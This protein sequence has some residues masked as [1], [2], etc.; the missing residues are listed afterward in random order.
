MIS[1]FS[2]QEKDSD[3][4][5]SIIIKDFE[6]FGLI[7][8]NSHEVAGLYFYYILDHLVE[9][10]YSVAVDF[11]VK[12]FHL[13]TNNESS[14]ALSLLKLYTRM[15][16]DEVFLSKEHR[17][18]IWNSL[19]G[20]PK[21]QDNYN[22][23]KYNFPEL[24]DTLLKAASDYVLR[25][26][27]ETGGPALISSFRLSLIPFKQ[28]I[29]SV[30][31]AAAKLYRNQ[32]FPRLTEENVYSILRNPSVTAVYGINTAV[33]AN[34]PYSFDSNANKVIEEVSCQLD[35]VDEYGHYFTQKRESYLET[36]AKRGAVAIAS[37]VNVDPDGSSDQE[38]LSLINQCYA[39]YTALQFLGMNSM[40][41]EKSTVKTEM[42]LLEQ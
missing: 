35:V 8:G 23:D 22:Q 37:A 34:W 31:G 25:A 13:F 24:R 6:T 14:N 39:W 18:H 12:R 1:S 15:G 41:M 40:S 33:N 26:E 16:N 38:I 3:I 5:Q 9:I 30:Q 2:Q 28:Y 10:A 29:F 32:V 36:I 27:I 42:A 11:S 7:A 19:F 20:K 21:D 17:H 4:N